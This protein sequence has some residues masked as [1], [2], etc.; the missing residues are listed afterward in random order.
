MCID[1]LLDEYL[2]L[3]KEM[4]IT[5]RK[6]ISGSYLYSSQAEELI[7]YLIG[8]GKFILCWNVLQHSYN[9]RKILENISKYA[10]H[11]SIICI[12]IEFETREIGHPA[13]IPEK[14]FMCKIKENFEGQDILLK[15]RPIKKIKRGVQ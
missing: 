12:S 1:P 10:Q 9:W 14:D 7:E 8:K 4:K 13:N 3:C 15:P 5:W 6:N 11:D 2:R